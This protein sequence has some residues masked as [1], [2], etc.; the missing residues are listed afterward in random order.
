MGDRLINRKE[1]VDKIAKQNHIIEALKQT[2]GI[3]TPSPIQQI[4]VSALGYDNN[5]EL[6]CKRDDL[7]H[8]IISGNKWRKLQPILTKALLNDVKSCLSFGGAYSNHLHALAYCCSKLGIKL[9]AI[10]RGER[11]T[12]LS[13]TLTDIESW[14]TQLHFVTRQEYKSR[15]ELEQ[16][17]KYKLQ[18]NT[19]LIIPEGGS[20][21]DAVFGMYSLVQEINAT[22]QHF[23]ALYTP[24]GS[25]ATLA[26]LIHYSRPICTK[27]IGV[28]V[29]KGEGYLEGLVSQL[30]PK[31]VINK[32]RNHW[33]ID[34]NFHHG[35]YAKTNP[36]LD[37]FI[38]AFSNTTEIGVEKVYSA[39]CMFAIHSHITR[40]L[41]KPN[42]K[43]LFL[44]TGGLQ[45]KRTIK[46]S[47]SEPL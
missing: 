29:L 6:W 42:S 23:D 7:L 19:E 8:P 3:K 36:E 18:F 25:G 13:P 40:D 16:I 22:S 11:P 12:N 38:N 2:L 14:G 9:T 32:A 28:A 17:K 10:I 39:K 43:I 30:L 45:G 27:V 34:H 26:G 21:E 44:H 4:D 20:N 31:D 47:I 46:R 33:Q 1:T 41:I 5:I 35:G 37:E 24:V 15:N